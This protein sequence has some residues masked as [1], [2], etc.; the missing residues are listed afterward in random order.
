MK[1]ESRT[2]RVYKYFKDHSTFTLHFLSIDTLELIMTTSHATDPEKSVSMENE[3]CALSSIFN[4]IFFA[5]VSL[6]FTRYCIMYH[7]QTRAWTR[8]IE[9]VCPRC[10]SPL[11][12]RWKNERAS[13]R[14]S[15]DKSDPAIKLCYVVP[16]EE[17]AQ[18][19]TKAPTTSLLVFLRHIVKTRAVKRRT[20]E[21]LSVFSARRG[22]KMSFVAGSNHVEFEQPN[23]TNS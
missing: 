9:P 6:A 16:R 14:N 8:I 20:S 4:S 22:T 2:F 12:F 21:R 11:L 7:D 5:N 3:I 17:G 10:R 1:E 18:V 13:W 23:Q 15:G 19:R